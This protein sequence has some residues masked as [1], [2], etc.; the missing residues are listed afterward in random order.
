MS[1]MA[2]QATRFLRPWVSQPAASFIALVVGNG[3]GH[4]TS[5][6][7]GTGI[8]PFSNLRE[9]GSFGLLHSRLDAASVAV[10]K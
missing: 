9:L 1:T 8:V 10:E 7:D 3:K 2:D 5:N 4:H 6:P